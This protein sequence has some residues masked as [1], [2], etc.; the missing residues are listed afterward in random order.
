M[1]PPGFGVVGSGGV[2]GGG[3]G[4]KKPANSGSSDGDPYS[5][6]PSGNDCVTHSDPALYEY[7]Y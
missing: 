4:S 7:E 5:L 3:G 6:T 1:N 2:G